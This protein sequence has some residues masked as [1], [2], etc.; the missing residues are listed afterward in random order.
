MKTTRLLSLLFSLLLAFT[1]LAPVYADASVDGR[2][3]RA[4]LRFLEGMIDHH[5]MALDMADDC[6]ER[7]STEALVTLCNDIISAQSAEIGQ[8]QQWLL[9]W[10]NVAYEPV[11]MM[12]MDGMDM[13]STNMGGMN[14]GGHAGH[15]QAAQA[16]PFTDPP[17][18]MGM[19]AGFNRLE[20]IDYEIAWLES[21]IDHHDDAIHMSERLLER[22]AETGHAE[23]ITLAE[24]IISDQRAE[25]ELMEALLLEL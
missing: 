2:E 18:M 14:M 25:I 1:L 3:G 8:M 16:G 10:Y 6:L 20:G 21:M 12:S 15:G 17:M 19:F 7:A 5:Q 4:E 23:L 13:G 9:D 11:S 24:T 22:L